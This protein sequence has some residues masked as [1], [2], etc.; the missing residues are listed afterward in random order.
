MK[1]SKEQNGLVLTEEEVKL[2]NDARLS[3][4][5]HNDNPKTNHIANIL[6]YLINGAKVIKSN[7]EYSYGKY[8]EFGEYSFI[9]GLNS[10]L[11]MIAHEIYLYVCN[12]ENHNEKCHNNLILDVIAYNSFIRSMK[13]DHSHLLINIDRCKN[14]LELAKYPTSDGSTIMN[15]LTCTPEEAIDFEFRDKQYGFNL[16]SRNDRK[17]VITILDN[18]KDN[19][20]FSDK[21]DNFKD[22][23]QVL[24]VMEACSI[25]L[26]ISIDDDTFILREVK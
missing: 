23:L 16:L 14:L 15:Y 5:A 7:D 19:H 21:V 18:F 26:S 12:V 1:Y 10:G 9:F 24:K 8:E 4:K 20:I 3:A 2:V 22:Y 25:K 6:L 17:K 13:E 11:I